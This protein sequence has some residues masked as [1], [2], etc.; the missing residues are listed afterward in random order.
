MALNFPASPA[1]NDIHTDGNYKFQWDGNKWVSIGP[2]GNLD[3]I[4]TATGNNKVVVS[5]T[6]NSLNITTNSATAVTVDDSQNVG[7][8]MSSPVYKLDVGDDGAYVAQFTQTNTSSAQGGINIVSDQGRGDLGDWNAISINANDNVSYDSRITWAFDSILEGPAI[9]GKRTSSSGTDLIFYTTE[10]ETLAERLRID[11]GGKIG[12]NTATPYESLSVRGTGDQINLDLNSTNDGDYSAI[13]WNTSNIDIGDNQGCAIRGVRTASGATGALDFLTRGSSNVL[14]HRMRI[15]ADG[16]VG[17]GTSSPIARLDVIDTGGGSIIRAQ[18]AGNDVLEIASEDN[19]MAL[20]CR[21]T[22]NGLRFQIQGTTYASFSTTGSFNCTS[23]NSTSNIT[24]TS[25]APQH[26]FKETG[27]TYGNL[28]WSLVRD[29]DS[30]SIRWNNAAPYGLSCTTSGGSVQ[31]V[32]LRGSALSMDSSNRLIVP[33]V[34]SQSGSGSTVVVTPAGFLRRSSSSIKYKKDVETIESSYSD[35]LLNCRPVWY[36]EKNSDEN[37]IDSTWG[38]WGFIAEEVAEIDPR[39]VHWKDRDVSFDDENQTVTTPC[40]LEPED[41]AYERFVPHLINLIKRQKE[42]IEA[43][44]ARV[45]AV[46][47]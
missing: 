38:Y 21:N 39:L 5:D 30:F 41:V 8:G 45:A 28:A 19:A 17:V 34:Y 46:E 16:D 22:T 4:R 42:A 1:L 10:S 43:L 31:N 37:T 3:E 20:D 36:R 18:G 33:T 6:D 2:E 35:A 14:H 44:E 24:Q 25:T 13:T 15:D 40:D 27:T 11:S 23:I 32:Q 47:A 7:I 12:I 9:G 26:I 29:S